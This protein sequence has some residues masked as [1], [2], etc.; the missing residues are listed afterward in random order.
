MQPISHDVSSNSINSTHSEFSNSAIIVCPSSMFVPPFYF[1]LHSCIS[2]RILGKILF[3]DIILFSLLM[4]FS[5]LGV[6]FY[7]LSSFLW[8]F[9]LSAA[10][11]DFA[12]V[13]SLFLTVFMLFPY[14]RCCSCYHL[15]CSRSLFLSF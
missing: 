7:F 5:F 3:S 10:I 2:P 14:S 6:F 15:P 8:L 4:R 12:V 13:F 1:C 11:V 9:C